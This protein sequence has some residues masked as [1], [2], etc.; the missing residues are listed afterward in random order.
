MKLQV[1]IEQEKEQC[2]DI[3]T[4]IL[5]CIKLPRTWSFDDTGCYMLMTPM[6]EILWL[7]K[8][9]I[10]F[11]PGIKYHLTHVKG[12]SGSTSY[13]SPGVQDEFIRMRVSC[14][15][16]VNAVTYYIGNPILSCILLSSSFAYCRKRIIMLSY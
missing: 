7:S 12:N 10:S 16:W 4:R 1:Q 11:Y 14:L 9:T 2:R 3:M 13:L 6:W 15:L 5:H 8:S